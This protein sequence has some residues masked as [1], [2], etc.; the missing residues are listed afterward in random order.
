MFVDARRRRRVRRL[1]AVA[2]RRA[3]RRRLRGAGRAGAD[4][5]IGV[6]SVDGRGAGRRGCSPAPGRRRWSRSTAASTAPASTPAEAGGVAAAAVEA[7]LPVRGV[8]T[9]PGHSYAPDALARGRGDDEARGA[10]GG[11]RRRSAPPASSPTS[12]AAAPR[13][14]LADSDTDVADRA[15]ARRLR[16]RRRP[17]VGAR[18]DRRRDRI[19]LTCRAT[20]VSHAGGR[21][22][23][24][25]RQQ[26]ARRRPGGV[27]HR[28]RAGSSTTRTRG[29]C[30]SPST[31]RS[32]TSPARRCRR[33]AAA[34][35]SY[36]NHVCAA[37]NL[38]D[39]ALGGRRD[40]AGPLAGGGPRPQ[41]LSA[42]LRS[43]HARRASALLALRRRPRPRRLLR[44]RRLR[45]DDRRP[46]PRADGSRP[47][48]LRL[49]RGRRSRP[50][51]R[52]TRRRRRPT[53]DRRGRRDDARRQRRRHRPSTLD[54][55]ATPCTVNSFVSLAEQ[56]YFD[57]TTCHRLTVDRP[58]SP[59]SSAATRPAP[60]RA[61]RATRSP[62]SSTGDETYPAGTL[63]MANAGPDTNGSQFFIVYGDTPL[64]PDYT[65]FGTRRRR[66]PRRSCEEIAAEGT[67]DRRRPTARRHAGRRSSRVTVETRAGTAP[68]SAP[69]TA[70]HSPRARSASSAVAAAPD[71][72]RP[73]AHLQEP[74][75]A[76]EGVARDVHGRGVQRGQRA[77]PERHPGQLVTPADPTQVLNALPVLP[78]IAVAVE[79]GC[80][81]TARTVEPA[82]AQPAV[83]LE[84]EEQVRELRGGV[85]PRTACRSAAPS[86]GRRGRPRRAVRVGGDHHDP[87]ARSGQQQVGQRE[88]AEV[89]GGQVGLEPVDGAA[90]TAPPSRRRC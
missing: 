79:P 10:G 52:S 27:R 89:V 25:R 77:L 12:S 18:H 75:R 42:S 28:L 2:V 61:A 83:Q 20:V 33:W 24:R 84:Q 22:V 48:V 50:P 67:D 69:R 76:D 41:R 35:T 43:A 60:A 64:P 36:P 68:R 46:R 56:G 58:A 90:R 62:T 34:S 1:P 19:A 44:R 59:C 17:A 72:G 63:A 80:A 49:P 31:T 15:A 47:V 82:V 7:G 85:R 38:V 8:F 14:S 53:R 29:S 81:P 30:S 71:L 51:R 23:A 65:V 86:S 57:D 13:P 70:S 5:A 6:D 3:G 21:L 45:P 88:V 55:D 74:V 4:L 32:S 26:G 78:V 9:F 87:V 11:G 37:V 16:L 54:A 73:A 66:R 39:D 40:G